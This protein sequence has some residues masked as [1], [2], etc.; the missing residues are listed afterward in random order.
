MIESSLELRPIHI[1]D[2]ELSKTIEEE[3][4]GKDFRSR[5]LLFKEFLFVVH[6]NVQT[7]LMTC[8]YINQSPTDGPENAGNY[9]GLDQQDTSLPA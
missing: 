9:I 1:L 7:V 6:F 2:P 3:Q 5:P 4:N 8:F